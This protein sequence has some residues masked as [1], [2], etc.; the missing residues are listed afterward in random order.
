M[1]FE[2]YKLEQG[3]IMIAYSEKNLSVGVLKL[4][5]GKELAK[6]NR[7][8]LESLFQLKGKCKM[9]VFEDDNS[10]IE[11]VLNEGESIN[12]SSLKFHIHSNPFDEESFTFWKA[13]GDI[14]EI[15]KDIRSGQ[16]M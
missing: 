10:F 14:T 11:V 12:I 3:S 13:T 8:A 9:K 5:P 2:E 1:N 4:M 6:H 15:I 16:K 7:P